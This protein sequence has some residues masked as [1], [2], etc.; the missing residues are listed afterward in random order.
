MAPCDFRSTALSPAGPLL[1]ALSARS[2]RNSVLGKWVGQRVRRQ[3]KEK[4]NPPESVLLSVAIT[5]QLPPLL[6]LPLTK[7]LNKSSGDMS[8]S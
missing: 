3:I 5:L 4:R 1:R 2:R 6:R 8:K 7:P